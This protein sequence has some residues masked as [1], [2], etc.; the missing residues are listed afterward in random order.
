MRTDKGD[1]IEFYEPDKGDTYKEQKHQID[2]V[3]F[4]NVRHPNL[5]YWHTVNEGLKHIHSALVDAQTGLLKGVSDF[6]FLI[7]FSSKYPFGAIEL[8]RVNKS[9]KGKASPVSAEQREF[10]RK[11]RELGGFS[12]V[13]YG[14][15]QLKIAVAEMLEQH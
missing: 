12:A 5:L 9:G 8:K 2:S 4:L 7:G 11:V 10:L 13:A 6:V 14:S 1:Y 15:E 3:T